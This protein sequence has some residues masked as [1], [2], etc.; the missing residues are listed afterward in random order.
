MNTIIRYL[1]ITVFGGGAVALLVLGLA[2]EARA[3][4]T[5]AQSAELLALYKPFICDVS[6]PANG[7]TQELTWRLTF[8]E[9]VGGVSWNDFLI[10]ET[11]EFVTGLPDGTP[12]RRYGLGTVWLNS[13]KISSTVYDI[14]MRWDCTASDNDCSH[15]EDYEPTYQQ[16]AR[17]DRYEGDV[18]LHLASDAE[19]NEMQSP[20]SPATRPHEDVT[21]PVTVW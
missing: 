3:Q 18:S 5:C 14:S 7:K 9:S 6:L 12:A 8:T 19:F 16:G 4:N 1:T 2:G 15:N 21:A 17:N 20:A 13:K 10:E 11:T